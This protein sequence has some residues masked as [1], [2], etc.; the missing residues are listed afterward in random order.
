MIDSNRPKKN[1]GFITVDSEP[2]HGTIFKVFLPRYE[3]VSADTIQEEAAEI[4]M[5]QS[6]TVLVVED[7]I[8]VLKLTSR[9]LEDLGYTVLTANTASEALGFAEHHD[10]QIHLLLSDVV[11]PGMNG[12]ELYYTSKALPSR[13][14]DSVY[15]RV[16]C[17]GGHCTSRCGGRGYQFYTK[18]LRL[19]QIGGSCSK[20]IG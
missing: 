6:E 19:A 13:Y 7:E 2:D 8:S 12:K 17:Q 15:V 9:I 5:A 20:S 4:L 3:D 18:T 16:Y 10:G 14:Q 11:M 1:K